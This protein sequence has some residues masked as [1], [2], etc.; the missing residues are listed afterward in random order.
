[1]TIIRKFNG[2][3]IWKFYRKHYRKARYRKWGERIIRR[4]DRDTPGWTGV[5]IL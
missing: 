5:L 3:T 4:C 2:E 1:M